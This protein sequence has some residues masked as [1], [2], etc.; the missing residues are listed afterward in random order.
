MV[1]L[2]KK[3]QKPPSYLID[4]NH[5]EGFKVARFMPLSLIFATVVSLVY[6]FEPVKKQAEVP[7]DIDAV[8]K[9]AQL[10]PG[11]E[12]RI[13]ENLLKTRPVVTALRKATGRPAFRL[14]PS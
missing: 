3:P 1:E 13:R 4:A 5:G 8:F 11:C 10:N 7:Q 2:E 12:K 6:F 14:R 9:K